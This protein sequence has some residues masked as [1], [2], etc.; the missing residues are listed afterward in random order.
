MASSLKLRLT[1]CAGDIHE[2][3]RYLAEFVRHLNKIKVTERKEKKKSVSQ[4]K[5]EKEVSL[6]AMKV[7]G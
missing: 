6:A 3:A 1:R 5:E 4:R 2:G 7:K